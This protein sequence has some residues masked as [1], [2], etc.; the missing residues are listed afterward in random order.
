MKGC[1]LSKQVLCFSGTT[2]MVVRLGGLHFRC[3]DPSSERV[4]GAT[5]GDAHFVTDHN[6]RAI[7]AATLSFR[8][9]MLRK[10][11]F[12][13]L[14]WY[15]NLQGGILAQVSSLTVESYEV[16]PNIALKWTANR[17]KSSAIQL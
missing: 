1:L 8:I 3:Q 12:I 13:I 14:A 2:V 9:R 7:I 5:A 10:E 6:T 16:R 11:R 15:V 17:I 4:V